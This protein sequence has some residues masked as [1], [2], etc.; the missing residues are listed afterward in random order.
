MKAGHFTGP[1]TMR[2]RAVGDPLCR[3]LDPYFERRRRGGG[4]GERGE[5]GA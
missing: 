3:G 5:L 2:L 4:M 1:L